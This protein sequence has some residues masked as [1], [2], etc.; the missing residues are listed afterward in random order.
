MSDAPAN[1]GSAAVVPKLPKA[2]LGVPQSPYISA[3]DAEAIK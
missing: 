1:H 3:L 2:N